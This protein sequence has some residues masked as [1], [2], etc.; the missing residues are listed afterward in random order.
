MEEGVKRW[1]EAGVKDFEEDFVEEVETGFQ[2][3]PTTKS[4]SCLP[5]GSSLRRKEH[6]VA[7]VSQ[8]R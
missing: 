1:A 6:Q 2:A 8:R 4:T 7:G 3:R 5:V